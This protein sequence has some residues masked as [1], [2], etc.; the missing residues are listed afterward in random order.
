MTSK[1]QNTSN[2][3]RKGKI[4]I[5]LQGRKLSLLNVRFFYSDP[6][7]TYFPSW[8]FGKNAIRNE[9]ERGF[10]LPVIM[11]SSKLVFIT[12]WEESEIMLTYC[13]INVLLQPQKTYCIRPSLIAAP[14]SRMLVT[15]T[16]VSPF[17]GWSDPPVMEKPRPLWPWNRIKLSYGMRKQSF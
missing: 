3:W 2:K 14:P 11:N 12:F 1:D 10:W 16:A 17:S 4:P 9:L 6:L 5:S 15:V 13:W 8:G 7:L